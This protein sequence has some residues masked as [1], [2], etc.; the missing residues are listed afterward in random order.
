MESSKQLKFNDLYPGLHL[1]L[2]RHEDRTKAPKGRA[3]L[4]ITGVR[5]DG[6]IG[7]VYEDGTPDYLTDQ[8]LLENWHISPGFG[9]PLWEVL[10]D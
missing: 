3:K 8:L 9:T 10:N 4:R 1:Q 2:F 6:W 7:I 5:R